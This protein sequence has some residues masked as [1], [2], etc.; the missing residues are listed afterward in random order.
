MTQRVGIDL[1]SVAA[2][3]EAV[4]THGQ[5]YLRR[6]FTAQEVTDCAGDP[7]RLAGRFAAKEAALKVLRPAADTAVPW[8]HIEVVRD[9]GGYVELVL[10]GLAADRALDEGLS[11]FSVS[12]SHEGEAACAVVSCEVAVS[13]SVQNGR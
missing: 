3:R 4:A 11:G 2:V 12:L 10:T 13:M 9:R 7:A 5:A 1:T 6:V 8:N